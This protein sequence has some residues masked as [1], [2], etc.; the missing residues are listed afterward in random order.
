M[1]E[2]QYY[3]FAAIDRSL[4]RTEIA[5]LRAVSTRAEITSTGF[6]NHYKW[7][8][9]KADPIDWMRRYFDAFVYTANWCSCR[10]CVRVPL[11]TFR[12]MELKPFTAGNALTIEA[13][14]ESREAERQVR[15][16]RAAWLKVSRTRDR[17]SLLRIVNG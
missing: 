11:P 8:D 6:A 10:L 7:G 4:T 13:S 17:T 2:C 9:L 1:S 5:Q 16:R 15:S 14:D 12:K 3:E